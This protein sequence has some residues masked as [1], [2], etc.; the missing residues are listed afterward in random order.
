MQV[1]E[2]EAGDIIA[3]AGIEGISIGDTISPFSTQKQAYLV[4]PVILP[5]GLSLQLR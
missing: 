3:F 1:D 4:N 5:P 2:V